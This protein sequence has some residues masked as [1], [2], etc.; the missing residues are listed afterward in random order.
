MN[1]EELTMK[2][3]ESVKSLGSVIEFDPSLKLGFD[4][5]PDFDVDPDISLHEVSA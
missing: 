2:L 4:D 3:F 1:H 5:E